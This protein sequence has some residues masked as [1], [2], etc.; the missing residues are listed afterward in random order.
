MHRRAI[1]KFALALIAV[2]A[3]SFGT[4]VGCKGS[5]NTDG[6]AADDNAGVGTAFVSDGGAGATIRID[7][8]GSLTTGGMVDFIVTLLDPNGNPLPFIRIFCE[9]ESGIAILE[10]SSGGVAFESTASNGIM[11]GVLGGVTPGSYILEC[12]AEQG[13]NLITRTNINVEGDV[14]T[15]FTGFPGAAGGNLGGGLLVEQPEEGLLTISSISI[16]DVGDTDGLRFDLTRDP[17]CDDDGNG[18]MGTIDPE[19]FVFNN[20]VVSVSNGLK[21]PISIGAVTFT[22]EGVTST[23]EFGLDVSAGATGTVTGLYTDEGGGAKEYAGT[24]VDATQG[25]RNVVFTVEVF[26]LLTGERTLLTD[27]QVIS[28]DFINNCGA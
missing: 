25:T 21:H 6:G 13:F 8:L 15:G 26:N 10:P 7:V 5:G 4:L 9:S 2:S 23:Q 22:V 18:P 11:S 3:L 27:S 20:F 14:P 12:R 19:P 28:A 17:D 16:T 24:G 1:T